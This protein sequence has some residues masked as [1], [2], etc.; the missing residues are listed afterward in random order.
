MVNGTQPFPL[1]S[2]V[3]Q[4]LCRRGAAYLQPERP[5]HTSCVNAL[6]PGSFLKLP[7]RL[8][9]NRAHA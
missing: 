2:V 8:L 3:R 1:M 7:R 4:E 9:Q 5:D 6:V